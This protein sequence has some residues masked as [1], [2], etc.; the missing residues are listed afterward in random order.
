[1]NTLATPSRFDEL[2]AAIAEL[3]QTDFETIHHFWPGGYGR[4]LRLPAGA[5]LTGKVHSG[6]CLNIVCGDI[7]VFNDVDGSVRRIVG[8][9]T[10]ISE[11]GTR[12]AGFA[13]RPTIWVCVHVN[14]TNETDL[15]KLEAMFIVPHQNPLLADNGRALQ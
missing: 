11:P 2:E 10:F 13:H 4:E 8:H 12:R 5:K 3:P 1:M 7:S 15:Q 14:P 6:Q 9:S